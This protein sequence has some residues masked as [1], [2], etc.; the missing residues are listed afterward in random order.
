MK[1]VIA[2]SLLLVMLAALACPVSASTFTPS[3][4]YKEEPQIVPVDKEEDENV[5]AIMYD[6]KDEAGEVIGRVEKRCLVFTPVSKVGTSDVIPAAAAAEL[7]KVYTELTNG[8]MTLP[9]EKLDDYNGETM[10]IRELFDASWL[11]STSGCD[12]DH[13]QTLAPEGVVLDLTLN[14][15]VAPDTKV[16]VMTYQDGQWNPIAGVRNNG[17]GT[18]TCIFEHF[19]PIAIAVEVDGVADQPQTGDDANVWLWVAVML[20]ALAAF[21]VV[22]LA[23]RNQMSGRKRK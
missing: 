22:A 19:C 17:D 7:K 2:V 10:V 9:Y 8:D 21:V 4:T 20:A 14:L 15:G 11:C 12:H 23:Y 5:I 6:F 3:V 1:K 13:S 16:V 18:V